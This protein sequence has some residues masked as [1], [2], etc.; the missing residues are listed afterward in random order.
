MQHVVGGGEGGA[1]VHG[2]IFSGLQNPGVSLRC[3]LQVE[4]WVW[5]RCT[6]IKGWAPNAA[7]SRTFVNV[8]ATPVLRDD[9][10]QHKMLSLAHLFS[11]I[12]LKNN[13]EHMHWTLWTSA[14]TR[15][16]GTWSKGTR[17]G[18]DRPG[19][20]S[21]FSAWDCAGRGGWPGLSQTPF[22]PP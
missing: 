11:F 17:L 22:P 3:G 1:G 18:L 20:V 9:D 21:C 14:G 12:L 8:T 19:F 16:Q 5:T 7:P 15:G 13:Q 2:R 10:C 6:S 4:A